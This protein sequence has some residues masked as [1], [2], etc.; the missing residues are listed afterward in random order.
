M[1][2]LGVLAYLVAP[3]LL[4]KVPGLVFVFREDPLYASFSAAS[5]TLG[6][7]AQ[8]DQHIAGFLLWIVGSLLIVAALAVLFF[9]WQ[10]EDRRMSLSDNLAVPV[11]PRALE[12]LFAVPGAWTTLE[13]VVAEISARLPAGPHGAE[14]AFAYRERPG[15]EADTQVILELHIALAGAHERLLARHVEQV[16]SECLGRLQPESRA[17]VARRFAFR[18]VTYGTRVG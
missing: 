3:F 10:A 2:Y 14:L 7:S 6:L 11:D 5:A 16:V 12:L 17:A 9:R 18:L 8:V 13:A 1:P 15:A 4:T